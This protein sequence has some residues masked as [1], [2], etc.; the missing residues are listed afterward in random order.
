MRKRTLANLS[1]LP[2]TVI[3]NLKIVL[4]GGTAIENLSE[5]FSIVRSL[6]YGH[7][8]ATLGTLRKIDLHNLIALESTRHRAL[9]EA[10]IVARIIEPRSKLATARGFNSETCSSSLSQILGVEKA[11]ADELYVDACVFS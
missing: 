11:D 2:D 3:E 9:I 1:K 6:P 10:M 4:K 7:V 8:A 5:S